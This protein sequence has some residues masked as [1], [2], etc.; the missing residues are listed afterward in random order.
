MCSEHGG[1]KYVKKGRTNYSRQ[2]RPTDGCSKVE[3]QQQ[4]KQKVEETKS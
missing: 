2:L 3:L 1:G 4:A